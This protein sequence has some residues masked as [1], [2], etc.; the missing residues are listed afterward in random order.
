MSRKEL[1]LAGIEPL[2]ERPPCAAICPDSPIAFE[3]PCNYVA[4][5]M[6][7]GIFLCGHHVGKRVVIVEIPDSVVRILTSRKARRDSA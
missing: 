1:T 6:R 3:H 2:S 4:R 5:W 7:E